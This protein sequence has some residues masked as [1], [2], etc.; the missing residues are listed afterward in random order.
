MKWIAFLLLVLGGSLA[1][2]TKAEQ[3]LYLD[4]GQV[5]LGLN[6]SA[7]ACV[8][9]FSHSHSSNNLLNAYDVGRY[10]QQAWYGDADGS[11]WDGKP[12][13]LNPVQGGAWRNEPSEILES[14]QQQGRHYVRL[15]PRHWATGQLLND[16]TFEQWACLQGGLARLRYVMHYHGSA[17]HKAR[18]QEL[19]ALYVG[20]QLDTL[21]LADAQGVLGALKPGGRNEYHKLAQP[22]LIWGRD[23]RDQS[24]ALGMWCPHAEQVTVF[25]VRQGNRADCSYAAALRTM[26][27]TPGMRYEYNATLA[28]GSVQQIQQVFSKL[29]QTASSCK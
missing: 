16:F 24:Q 12:W 18:H 7:G 10:L 1:A 2:Q 8:G 29:N 19:P 3:W 28:I 6:L 21:W 25:R 11:D 14:S 27:L 9:W 15:R 5:R 22:W 23:D 13:N 4:N 20:P 26:A 17:T